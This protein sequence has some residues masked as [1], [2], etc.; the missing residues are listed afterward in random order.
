MKA[1]INFLAGPR[2]AAAQR[3]SS[4]RRGHPPPNFVTVRI[5]QEKRAAEPRISRSSSTG[6]IGGLRLIRIRQIPAASRNAASP[7]R[8]VAERDPHTR[9]FSSRPPYDRQGASSRLCRR[10]RCQQLDKRAERLL[11]RDDRARRTRRHPHRRSC[12]RR[13]APGGIR[14]AVGT[15]PI[16]FGLPS[17]DG[18]VVF[19]MGTSAFML[20]DARTATGPAIAAVFRPAIPGI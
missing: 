11:C 8:N 15:N 17:G 4:G 5:D 9:D 6:L 7:R 18:P 1:V 16:A 20:T 12:P 14:P 19:D 10:R 3:P 13:G 2:A